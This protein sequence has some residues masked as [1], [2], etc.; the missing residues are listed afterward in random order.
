MP[1]YRHARQRGVDVDVMK[2]GR[3]SELERWVADEVMPHERSVR[4]WLIRSGFAPED[5]EEVVQDCYCHFAGLSGWSHIERPD[6]Y[7]FTMARNA[8]TRR[9]RRRKIVRIETLSAREVA[10]LIDEMPSPER[11]AAARLEIERLQAV[12]ETLPQ[13]CRQIITLR[14]FEGL[15]QRQ[16]AERLNITESI[17]ENDLV[18]GMAA[19]QQV[20]RKVHSAE[21]DSHSSVQASRS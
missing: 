1:L 10:E 3:G 12:L 20:W 7:F 21:R 17:V 4:R 16:I 5:V 11:H 15:S 18:R 13:R 9:L 8:M 14:K 19:I 2:G 6:A